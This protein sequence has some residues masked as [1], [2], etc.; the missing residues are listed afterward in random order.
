MS[1]LLD[2]RSI[3]LWIAPFFR[4]QNEPFKKRWFSLDSQTR[5]LFYYK[6]QL[7]RR[8]RLFLLLLSHTLPCQKVKICHFVTAN[9]GCRG[10]RCDIHR[11]REQRLRCEGV[12]PQEC[13]GE[14]V[15]V[16]LDS[17]HARA[18]VCPDVRA[19]TGAGRVAAGAQAG[20]AA[21]HGAAGLRQ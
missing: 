13:T 7:V 16:R 3:V 4:Q 2:L 15:E 18:T 9:T 17:N 6:G 12:C 10:I 14:Q 5:K 1:N 8:K 21:A 11:H 20:P 19:G